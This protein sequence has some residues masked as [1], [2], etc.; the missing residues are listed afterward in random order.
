MVL[1]GLLALHELL[2]SGKGTERVHDDL[3]GIG[4]RAKV[5]LTFGDVSG[6]VRDS[7]RD[8]TVI[9]S[10]H[11]D[12]G[13]G[14]ARR[15]L[16]GL[17]VD[18]REIGIQR[19]GH[20]VLGRDLVHTVGHDRKGVRIQRHVREEHEHLL[21]L[22]HGEVLCRRE[23]HIRDEQALYRGLFGGVHERNDPVKRARV[24]ELVAEEQIVVVRKAHAS[25]DDLVHVCAES[26]ISHNFVVRLVG[27]CEE[28]DLLAG[29]E[30]VVEVDTGDTGRD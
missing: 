10:G 14:A 5:K 30:G 18:L 4:V 16:H 11:G 7:V 21:V 22:V 29:D 6:V 27:V 12:D 17:F 2:E 24:L 23:R 9:Q 26:H 28:R 15:K 8:V 13:D 19:A 1:A 25:E 3:S 20:G